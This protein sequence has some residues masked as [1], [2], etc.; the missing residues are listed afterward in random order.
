[1]RKCS[2]TSKLKMILA[3]RSS[4]G[5]DDASRHGAESTPAVAVMSKPLARENTP[6]RAARRL[7]P[8]RGKDDRRGVGHPI[9]DDEEGRRGGSSNRDPPVY[10]KLMPANS[11]RPA[12]VAS[13]FF[14]NSCGRI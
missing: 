10:A 13:H 6:P 2:S 7:L 5:H 4:G 1:M 9:A 11:R 14:L 3:E 8:A 12:F